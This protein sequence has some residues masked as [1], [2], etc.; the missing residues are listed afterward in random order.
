MIT[1]TETPQTSPTPTAVTPPR[2]APRADARYAPETAGA[3]MTTAYTAVAGDLTVADALDSVRVQAVAAETIYTIYVLGPGGRLDGVVSLRELLIAN[4]A[5]PVSDVMTHPAVHVTTDTDQEHVVRVFM[6]LDSLAVPVVDDA[7]RLVG[8]VTVDDALDVQEDEATEDIYK[9]EG[10]VGVESSRSEVLVRGSVASILKVRLPFL[11]IT[12]VAGMIAGV[13]VEGFEEQLA[14]VAAVAVF[15]PL[16]M[17]MGGN[18]G[19]QSTTVFARA[20]ALGHLDL[21]RFGRAFLKEVTVGFVI[22]AL[23]GTLA[24]LVA[25]VWQGM[26]YLGWAVGLSLVATVTLSAALG[27]FVPWLLVKLGV[28]QAAGSAPIITSVKDI[29]GLLIYFSFTALFLG[30]LL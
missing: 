19:S 1:F 21:K 30:H 2:T 10:L 27:F 25:G 14:S 11:L 12:L 29:S 20:L 28:D 22:G 26:P 6:E 5:A 16:I 18:V 17:D 23:V 7:G 9:S 8:I 3:L 4:P 24:G 15:I 13:V